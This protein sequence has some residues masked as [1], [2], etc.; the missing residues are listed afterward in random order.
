MPDRRILHWKYLALK[1]KP[2]HIVSAVQAA[3]HLESL[4]GCFDR[5]G[6]FERLPA[7]V[8][9]SL[10]VPSSLKVA[11]MGA[12][13]ILAADLKVVSVYV[14]IGRLYRWTPPA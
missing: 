9:A 5:Y 14:T 4:T 12:K 10:L 7:T 8:D 3:W 1:V 11:L 13:V 2:M 6:R